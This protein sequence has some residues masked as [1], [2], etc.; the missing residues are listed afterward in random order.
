MPQGT[1]A[2]K[3]L[4][5]SLRGV[6]FSGGTTVPAFNSHTD[7][8]VWMDCADIK[9]ALVWNSL[10]IAP[11]YN[12]LQGSSATLSTPGT[13]R[14]SDISLVPQLWSI[15]YHGQEE[16]SFLLHFHL[17]EHD[18]TL[19]KLFPAVGGVQWRNTDIKRATSS[20]GSFLITHWSQTKLW[21]APSLTHQLSLPKE[22]AE[23]KTC[24]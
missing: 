1:N 13:T 10:L 22:N 21:T 18:L 17:H 23:P 16:T 24:W 8:A 11:V 2:G 19:L 14:Q 7:N 20:L 4:G 15:T 9:H 5:A 3:L 6:R 12:P